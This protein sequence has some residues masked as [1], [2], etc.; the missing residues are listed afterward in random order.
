VL[1]SLVVCFFARGVYTSEVAL[2]ALATVGV[3]RTADDLLRMG[4]ETLHLKD[5]FKRREGYDVTALRI[6]ARILETESP[7]GV[8]DEAFMREALQQFADKV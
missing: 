3:E 5:A 4:A 1:A 2:R 6:P 8:V 7:L